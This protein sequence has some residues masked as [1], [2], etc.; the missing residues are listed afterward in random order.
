MADNHSRTEEEKA[1]QNTSPSGQEPKESDDLSTVFAYHERTK[2][3][4]HH[5]AE[6]PDGLDWAS[7][8]HP[9][10]QFLGAPETQLLLP[11]SDTTPDYDAFF[12]GQAVNSQPLSLQTLS[13]FFYYSLALSAWKSCFGNRWSLRVNPSSGNLHPTECYLLTD[14]VPGLSQH[15]G[16]YHYYP[17][18][19]QLECR[20]ELQE[21]DWKYLTTGITSG[22]STSEALPK[23]SFLIALCSIH[24]RE[25][26][27][28]G[29]RAFRYCQHDCGHALA[30]TTIAAG[31]MGWQLTL[32]E[33]ISDADLAHLLGVDRDDDYPSQQEREAPDLLAVV[34][35]IGTSINANW[36]PSLETLNT[37]ATR[38][39]HGKANPLSSSHRLWPWIDKATSACEKPTT[40][41]HNSEYP[42]PSKPMKIK[43]ISG[44]SATRSIGAIIRQRRSALDMDGETRIDKMTFYQILSRILPEQNARLF[45]ATAWPARVHLGLFVHRVDGLQ[46]G[47]YLLLRDPAKAEQLKALMSEAFI[48]QRPPDCPEWLP[49]Y[50]LYPADTQEA[51]K[52][53]SCHQEIA[54]GGVFSCAMLAEFEQPLRQLGTWWYRRLFWE[55][56]IIGQMLYLEA[57]AKGIRATGIG[58]YF[59]DPVHE[60]FGIKDRSYQSL[61]HFTMGGPVEDTRLE[62][63]PA[64]HFMT[65]NKE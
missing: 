18:R 57:E 38:E 51:A 52:L 33:G 39:W 2:H 1:P 29:E 36:R 4:F 64:Y 63:L 11:D 42:Q 13:R 41:S 8:P 34:S 45:S 53:L 37:L 30:A 24:W 7:Q 16:I 44:S 59:D 46:P 20:L 23:G 32:V 5:Y 56:G 58:C 49:L 10:R 54:S 26:W 21:P 31:L 27:K 25:S 22:L 55:T 14:T 65:E 47:L 50:C 17:L 35:P 60:V 6:G 40:E 12:N 28:Y 15:P 61:Y 48:W 43:A 62:T 9:F 3:H 19:H